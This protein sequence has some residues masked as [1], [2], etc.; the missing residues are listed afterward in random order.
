MAR[1]CGLGP[2]LRAAILGGMTVP[3]LVVVT[4]PAGSGKTSLAHALAAAIG[5]PAICRDEIKKGM[6]FGKTDFVPSVGDRQTRPL[7]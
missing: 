6:A 5:C 2:V 3:V 4:G 1:S 7:G